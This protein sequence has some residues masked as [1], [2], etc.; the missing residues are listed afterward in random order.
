MVTFSSVFLMLTLNS[1]TYRCHRIWW[2]FS[3]LWP[4]SDFDLNS[5]T[6]MKR[7]SRRAGSTEADSQH[8]C[9]FWL[10]LSERILTFHNSLSISTKSSPVFSPFSLLS[11]LSHPQFNV[12]F[13]Y[14][15]ISVTDFFSHLNRDIREDEE[16]LNFTAQKANKT[17][18]VQSR[19]NAGILFWIENWFKVLFYMMF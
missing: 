5:L 11:S 4:D 9:V 8:L 15:H 3:F 18:A 17:K 13:L 19:M 1:L 16:Y 14:S 10:S 2:P 7:R 6:F 12:N